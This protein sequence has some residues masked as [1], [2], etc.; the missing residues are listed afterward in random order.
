[1]AA[2]RE[3]RFGII[4][5]GMMGREFAS[6]AA[7]WCHLLDLD[8]VPRVA[9]IC[10]RS[11]SKFGWFTTHFDTIRLATTDYRDMLDPTVVDA[12]YCAV[13]HDQHADLYTDIIA[14]GI[15]LLGEK[16]FGIDAAANGRIL[17]ALDERHQ[18]VAGGI[19]E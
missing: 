15:P 4:G 2:R 8:F 13:P 7:R 12:V 9:A 1:M 6:A 16:P 19:F 17:A 10:S 18:F 5:L 11:A 14:A 3:I